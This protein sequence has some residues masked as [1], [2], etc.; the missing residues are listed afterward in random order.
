M[1]GNI[2]TTRKTRKRTT[3]AY[4]LDAS[5]AASEVFNCSERNFYELRKHPDFPP[6]VI[7]GPRTVRYLRTSLEKFI[8]KLI[9]DVAPQEPAQLIAGKAKRAAKRQQ[10]SA[11]AVG[12]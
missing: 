8:D 2:S 1:T 9:A 3:D 12:E 5:A 4:L 7:L 6:P 11:H 10:G